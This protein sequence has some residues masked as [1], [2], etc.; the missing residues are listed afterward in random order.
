M[1]GGKVLE[2]ASGAPQVVNADGSAFT[3]MALDSL[4]QAM[5][6]GLRR[7]SLRCL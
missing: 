7:L 2:W 6:L 5:A 1:A 3:G 4:P